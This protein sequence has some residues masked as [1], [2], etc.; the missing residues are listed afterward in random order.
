[1]KKKIHNFK[2]GNKVIINGLM[3]GI[4]FI[5]EKGTIISNLK[6]LTDTYA[7]KFDKPRNVFHNCDGLCENKYGWYVHSENITLNIPYHKIIK[8]IIEEK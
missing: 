6:Y 5:N 4:Q 2:I 3:T 7:I 8:K 1:M